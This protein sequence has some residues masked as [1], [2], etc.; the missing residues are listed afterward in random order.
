MN[1]QQC[2]IR[3]LRFFTHTRVGS[4]EGMVA[5]YANYSEKSLKKK[6]FCYILEIFFKAIFLAHIKISGFIKIAKL[7]VHGHFDASKPCDF[8]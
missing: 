3:V 7:L 2:R 6:H 5:L 8:S 4:L 1:A